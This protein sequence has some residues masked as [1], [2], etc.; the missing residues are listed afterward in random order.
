MYKSEHG[1]YKIKIFYVRNAKKLIFAYGAI[2]FQQTWM[3][4]KNSVRQLL[5]L[6]TRTQGYIKYRFILKEKSIVNYGQR[7]STYF[8]FR[9]FWVIQG[10][11]LSQ[12]CAATRSVS[13]SSNNYRN[14]QINSRDWYD[15]MTCRHAEHIEVMSAYIA[16]L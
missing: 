16:I 13:L 15:K 6:M 10:L 9:W 14:V 4:R 8:G 3:N 1:H 2:F 7:R 11:D 12:C 5:N